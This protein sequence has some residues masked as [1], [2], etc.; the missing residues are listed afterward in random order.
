MR[1]RDEVV[2]VLLLESR[3]E[4]FIRAEADRACGIRS[5]LVYAAHIDL[6]LVAPVVVESTDSLPVV[7]GNA[8]AQIR[9]LWANEPDRRPED[10]PA[11]C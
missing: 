3:V 10:C 9:S 1:H 5:F 2:L 8:A 11:D 7:A 4:S 6:G